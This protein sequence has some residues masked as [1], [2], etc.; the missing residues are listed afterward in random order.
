[1]EKLVILYLLW[2]EHDPQSERIFGFV[3]AAHFYFNKSVAQLSD[4]EYLSMI[5]MLPAQEYFNLR[6]HPKENAERVAMLKRGVG[7]FAK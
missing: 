4:D 7:G 1:M 3:D 6:T 5:A 2:F